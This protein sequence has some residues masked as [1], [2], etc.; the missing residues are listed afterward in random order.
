MADGVKTKSVP[1]TVI[2]LTSVG[3]ITAEVVDVFVELSLADGRLVC[4][5]DGVG[6]VGRLIALAAK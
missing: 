6:A 5:V 2:S 3:E 1:V 4:V